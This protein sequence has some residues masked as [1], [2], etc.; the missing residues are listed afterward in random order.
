MYNQISFKKVTAVKTAQTG[1]VS[2][3]V[4]R[5]VSGGAYASSVYAGAGGLGTKISSS[6]QNATFAGGYIQYGGI[7]IRGNEKETM[8]NLNERLASYIDQV[9]SLENANAKL[10]GQIREW[11]SKNSGSSERDDKQY[12]QIIEEL[13]K[14]ILDAKIENASVFLQIDNARLAAEDLK[15]KF[16]NEQMFRIAV[17]KDTAELRKGMDQL[18]I[19]RADLEIQIE[20]LTEEFIHLK[21]N[22][23]EEMD[24]L[25]KQATGAVNVEVDVAP[26]VDLGKIM[27]EMRAQYEQVVEKYRSE[28]RTVFD[29][30]VEEWNMEIQTNTSELEKCKKEVKEYRQK[31]QE[32]E[33]ESE[34]LLS[35]KNVAIA[36]L[37]NIDAQYAIQL[38]EV[39]ENINNIETLLQRTRKDVGNQVSEFTLL[40]SLKNKLEAEIATYRNLLDGA[41]SSIPK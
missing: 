21:K 1:S 35:K 11:Y 3:G 14:Q 39:Q 5:K 24:D 40:L 16:E 19:T 23:K 4:Y 25:H 17:E 13:K 15:K 18:T 30:K 8:Q 29:R 41:A 26:P 32:L 36:M 34:A 20:S 2:S 9:H 31:V 27:E 6:S 7:R 38:A 22:H 33:I 12:F 10:E 37:E 28:A